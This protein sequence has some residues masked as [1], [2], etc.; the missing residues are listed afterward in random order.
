M[1]TK[2]LTQIRIQYRKYFTPKSKKLKPRHYAKKIL[3]RQAGN[4]IIYTKLK[5]N[6]PLMVSRYG[7]TEL[8][9]VMNYIENKKKNIVST[10]DWFKTSEYNG[11]IFPRTDEIFR[12]FVQ[13]YIE[14][15]KKIDAL[16]VWYNK[17]E[18]IICKKFCPEAELIP[19]QSIEP[20]F[21]ENPWSYAL[22]GKKVLVIHP[23]AKSI[24]KQY[25]KNRINLFKDRNI[26]PNFELIT[27]KSFI[28][29]PGETIPYDSWFDVLDSIQKQIVEQNFDIALIGAG[30]YGLPIAAYI[31]DIGKQAI[32]LGGST[33]ILFGIIGSRWEK[34]KLISPL[35]NQFWVR[36]LPEETPKN[37]MQIE[38][39]C[40][41]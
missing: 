36:P 39:G 12:K 20:Y 11:G 10:P 23:F 41:W 1:I 40:Y 32:H 2:I 37:Y 4:D 27:I 29:I 7:S 33:Q 25:K 8:A 13:L 14:S 35:F 31:K 24:E 21:H 16:G 26:L 19:L 6:K 30:P 3:S 15:T 22:K 5:A 18:N 34:H 17:G 9:Y 38:N 28:T